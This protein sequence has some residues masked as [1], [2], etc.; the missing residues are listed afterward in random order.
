MLG[1]S[2]R[3]LDDEEVSELREWVTDAFENPVEEGNYPSPEQQTDAGSEDRTA[4]VT[5][6]V[7]SE[8]AGLDAFKSSD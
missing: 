6:S 3:E 4:P 7:S 5:A 2:V 1:G 8:Q